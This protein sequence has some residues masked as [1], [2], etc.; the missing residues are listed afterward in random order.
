MVR[1]CPTGNATPYEHRN[2]NYPLEPC[3]KTFVYKKSKYSFIEV[4][5]IPVG[6]A[7][8]HVLIEIIKVNGTNDRF[9]PLENLFKCN[10]Y[11]SSVNKNETVAYQVNEY[12][13]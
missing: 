12:I 4:E 2:M 6:D 7:G 10:M 1:N 11:E 13:T 5:S 8:R 9:E 3:T